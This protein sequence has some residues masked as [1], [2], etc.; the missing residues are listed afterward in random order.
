MFNF[1]FIQTTHKNVPVVTFLQNNP[2]F[3]LAGVAFINLQLL[4][5]I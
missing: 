5:E 2:T 4:L 1:T 3:L